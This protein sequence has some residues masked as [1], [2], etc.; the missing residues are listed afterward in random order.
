MNKTGRQGPNRPQGAKAKTERPAAIGPI[1]VLG[2]DDRREHIVRAD[3]EAQEEA[4][5][6]QPGDVRREGLGQGRGPEEQ[7]VE[8]IEAPPA[9]LSQD[10]EDEGA[11]GR[12]DQG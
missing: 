8:A 4:E 12:A 5:G 10:A 7:D 3:A 1:G 9:A 11:E 6:D 2:H